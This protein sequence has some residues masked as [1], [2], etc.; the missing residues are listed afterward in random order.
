RQPR[1]AGARAAG[2]RPRRRVAGRGGRPRPQ[3]DPR[4]GA[5]DAGHGPD[6]A[7]GAAGPR[8]RRCPV[9]AGPT[10]GV[11]PPRMARPPDVV[12]RAARAHGGDERD[13]DQHGAR[14]RAPG[15]P[16]RHDGAV[17]GL[18]PWSPQAPDDPGLAALL[19]AARTAAGDP[20]AA[21]AL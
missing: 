16:G 13:A 15:P 17:I 12:G 10:A 2:G 5:P 1:A 18:D 20:V 21:L 9:A 8:L 19:E 6:D 4:L 3:P 11:R 14:G 7:R